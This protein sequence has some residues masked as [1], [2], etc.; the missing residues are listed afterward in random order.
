[1]YRRNR[2]CDNPRR[3]MC[4]GGRPVKLSVSLSAEVVATLPDQ[5]VPFTKNFAASEARKVEVLSI[6]V[7]VETTDE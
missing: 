6:T 7:T 3:I 2:N 1:M 4:A 5:G